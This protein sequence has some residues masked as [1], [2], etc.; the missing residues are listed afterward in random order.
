MAAPGRFNRGELVTLTK[1]ALGNRTGG[2]LSDAWYSD[3]VN[4]AYARLTTFQGL[5]MAPGMRRPRFRVLRFFELYNDD[6]RTIAA[7]D[8]ATSNFITPASSSPVVYVDNVYNLTDDRQMARKSIRYMH[9]LNPQQTGKPLRWAPGGKAAPGYYIHPI[10][11]STSDSL[12]VREH[13]YQYPDEMTADG[14]YPVVPGV[15]HSGIWMA[16]A[17]EGASLIDWPEKSAEMEQK[18][19]AFI[20]ER[21]SPVEESGAAGGRRHFTI[22]GM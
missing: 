21:R 8:V 12:T 4:T 10:P 17:A 3:R 16:A 13:T 7:A 1:Q 15:W 20:A 18:F 5:V 2:N 9:T 6:D 19:M 22:G 14:D 11:S